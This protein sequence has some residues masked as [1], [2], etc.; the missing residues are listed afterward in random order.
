MLD[1]NARKSQSEAGATA[2]ELYLNEMATSSDLCSAKYRRS[3][4]L[5]WLGWNGMAPGC[6]DFHL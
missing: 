6:H 3:H 1:N 2:W 5:A 4:V